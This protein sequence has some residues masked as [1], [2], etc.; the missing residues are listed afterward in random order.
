M[1]LLLRRKFIL[2]FFK[3]YNI[4]II[5]HIWHDVL[6]WHDTT[7]LM[8]QVTAQT[9]KQPGVCSAHPPVEYSLYLSIKNNL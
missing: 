3:S 6:R 7:S 9:E 5:I 8:L 4:N 2:F 1:V